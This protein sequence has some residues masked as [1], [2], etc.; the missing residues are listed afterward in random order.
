MAELAD[1]YGSGPYGETRG[2]SSPLASSYHRVERFSA[3][4]RL[5]LNCQIASNSLSPGFPSR[6]PSSPHQ[7]R[8]PFSAGR[9][10]GTLLSRRGFLCTP[11]FPSCCPTSFHQL[12]KLPSTGRCELSLLLRRSCPA[13]AS[14]LCPTG[15]GGCRKLRSGSRREVAS[16]GRR[17]GL[18]LRCTSQNGGKASLQIIDLLAN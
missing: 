7:F 9:S 8:K 13:C 5:L 11:C 15:S 14:H 3:G 10:E 1:A 2:G 4:D 16:G 12:R 17:T 6:C 18:P